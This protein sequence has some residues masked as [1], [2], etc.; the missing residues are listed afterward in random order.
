MFLG[1]L[2]LASCLP[3]F[4]PSARPLLVVS[5]L[6]LH[7]SS[8]HD[9]SIFHLTTSSL[10]PAPD[11]CL[12]PCCCRYQGHGVPTIRTL[13]TLSIAEVPSDS[14]VFTLYFTT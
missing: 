14:S 11:I 6:S 1:L 9:P 12:P 10:T 2:S 3:P 8:V 4:C 13:R 5:P 7:P